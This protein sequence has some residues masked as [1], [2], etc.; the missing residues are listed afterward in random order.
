[1]TFAFTQRLDQIWASRAKGFPADREQV[2]VP[3]GGSFP[4]GAKAEAA[5][6]QQ[7]SNSSRWRMASLLI[8]LGLLCRN[9]P[10]LFYPVWP[11]GVALEWVSRGNQSE[12]RVLRRPCWTFNLSPCLESGLV[13]DIATCLYNA[14]VFSPFKHLTGWMSWHG[15]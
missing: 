4:R 13:I 3:L 11:Y 15:L 6:D 9:P 8:P 1:M 12:L 2:E 7:F 14:H 5:S 10:F